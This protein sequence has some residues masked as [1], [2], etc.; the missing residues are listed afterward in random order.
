M[1]GEIR[2]RFG[3]A[4]LLCLA[5][6]SVVWAKREPWPHEVS[7][8]PPAPEVVWGEL[9]NGFRFALLPR[10]QK[11][12][13]IS[14]RLMVG[15]GSLDEKEDERGL[16]HF[17][18]HMAFEGTRSFGPGELIAF[19]QRLG[20]SYG[21]DVNAFTYHSKTVYHLELPQ[22]EGALIKQ[23]LT[24][25]RDYADGILFTEDRID[26]ER[27]VI[28]RERQ[29]RESPSSRIAQDSFGFAFAGTLLANRNP[30]GLPD[31]VANVSREKLMEFYRKW[32]RADVM[33]LVAVGDFDPES[34]ARMIREGFEGMDKPK[35]SPPKRRLGRLQKA[36][37]FRTGSS[38]VQGIERYTLEVSR[39]WSEPGSQRDSW[40]LRREDAAR[41]FATAI[42]NERCRRAIDGM[43]ENFASYD[44]VF[45]F[46]YSH[47][48]ISSGGA[49]WWEGFIWI[50]RMLRQA[51]AYG[52]TQTELEYQRKIWRQG[53]KARVAHEISAEP[54]ELIDELVETIDAGRVYM[55]AAEY[56]ARM[57]AFLD[58]LTVE[59]LN[60]SFA[61]VWKLK[62]M[63]YFAAGSFEEPIDRRALRDAL[64]AD[65]K[66]LMPP[67]L[68]AQP[69]AFAYGELGEAGT[70][71][72]QGEIEEIGARTYRFQNNVRLTFLQ[73]ENEKDMVR[74]SVRVGGGMLAFRD[75]NPG[76]HALAMPSLFRSGFGGHDIEDVYSELRSNVASF[77]FG[78]DDHDAFSFHVVTPTEGMES[79]LKI[80]AAY[81]REPKV[82]PEAFNLA[83]LKLRQSRELES[84]GLNEGYRSLHRM[85]YPNQPR[86]HAPSLE[87]IVLADLEPIKEWVEGPLG[88]GYLEI[89]I[90]GDV[91]EQRLVEL[92]GQ[93]LGALPLRDAAKDEFAE[94]RALKI[95]PGK[96][97]SR[98]EYEKGKGDG[99]AAVVVWTIQDDLDFRESTALYILSELFEE[100]IR[101]RA[102]QKMG[103]TYAPTVS[104]VSYP[105]YDTLRHLRADVDCLPRDAD[106]LLD[107][108]LEI[109]TELSSKEVGPEELKAA[110]APLEE[111]LK[112][113][114]RDN[115]YL[116][117]HVLYGAQ[118][119]PGI[120]ANA[121]RY[122]DGFLSS[123]SADEILAVARRYLRTDEALA[124]AIA[125]ALEARLAETP[126][127]A[128]QREAA[129]AR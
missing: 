44:R 36:S 58:G 74:S 82:A 85:L 92:V 63:S 124:V 80:M 113:A 7:D 25:F 97:K 1:R 4:V 29:A 105:A 47:I 33:T 56:G 121:L 18:E 114:W 60:A 106:A 41:T 5:L 103:A 125:P 115:G 110:V 90:V 21:V 126:E 104:Y 94:T 51:L 34:M 16:A 15:V 22:G 43:S 69:E 91:E 107:A 55:S 108:V 6:A 10:A 20:M 38:I 66:F 118:E 72:E 87:D 59:E 100:R 95:S 26:K 2:I 62:G 35:G 89:A 14:M 70:V 52:F 68:V 71:V 57:E 17:V 120:V 39:S 27:E 8:L 119:Y 123:I 49:D 53:F 111:S 128:P 37:P 117:D 48:S 122:R 88:S 23:G 129:G 77:V 116:L 101:Q 93:T 28:Q 83:R 84:D 3:F 46:P 127:A 50:D 54:R 67:Y 112:L 99:A 81:L 75:A 79:F 76:T 109:A 9:E 78:I 86:F 73:T 45:S 61:R 19:F 64:M 40:K 11:A 42:F 31:V 32:Y 12:G 98:I 96:G 30:I 65:R 13:A 102:R 24:L